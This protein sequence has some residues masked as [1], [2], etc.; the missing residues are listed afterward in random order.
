MQTIFCA[1]VSSCQM[2]AING[3][4]KKRRRAALV[5]Q[6]EQ[7][8]AAEREFMEGKGHLGAIVGQARQIETRRRLKLD[9]LQTR[10]VLSD[11]CSAHIVR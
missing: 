4:V 7:L 9:M 1:S 2:D 10:Y 8:S 5:E 11:C 6:E 3:G